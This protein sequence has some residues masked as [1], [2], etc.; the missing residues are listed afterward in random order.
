M[1]NAS[2]YWISGTLFQRTEKR[3]ELNHP[4][5]ALIIYYILFKEK[6]K[7]CS[8]W[9]CYITLIIKVFY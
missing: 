7:K 5:F 9:D 6:R 4:K 8:I 2:P 3:K 1:S